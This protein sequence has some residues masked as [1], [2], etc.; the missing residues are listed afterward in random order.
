MA[1]KIRFDL[2]NENFDNYFANRMMEVTE[3]G[4]ARIP[5]YLNVKLWK[6]DGT[7]NLKSLPRLNALVRLWLLQKSLNKKVYIIIEDEKGLSDEDFF[8]WKSGLM[9]QKESIELAEIFDTQANFF[10]GDK[11]LCR[12]LSYLN[13]MSV[14]SAYN[15]VSKIKNIPKNKVQEF[16]KEC[17][18]V[19]DFLANFESK[20]KRMVTEQNL[21][22]AEFYTL[23]A[24]Y[25]GKPMLA[26]SIYTEK[27]KSAYVAS[28][29]QI[30]RGFI[31]LQNCGYIEKIGFRKGAKFKITAAGM[32][33]VDDIMRQYF[34]NF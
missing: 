28:R 6:G 19:A 18:Y 4:K 17:Q 32:G 34:I 24:L 1:T 15:Y 30:Q 10:L 8:K 22:I 27:F 29:I 11:E 21:N 9:S 3:F 7:F 12:T 14:S 26:S 33:K 25:N 31:T 23:L 16:R 20:K 2:I 5:P 13:Q